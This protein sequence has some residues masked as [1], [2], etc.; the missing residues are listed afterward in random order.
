MA[1]IP[2][3]IAALPQERRFCWVPGE[4][5]RGLSIDGSQ[6]QVHLGAAAAPFFFTWKA[7]EQCHPVGGTEWETSSIYIRLNLNIRLNGIYLHWH[8]GIERE[9][10]R[11]ARRH[12]AGFEGKN[13]PLVSGIRLNQAQPSV[14]SLSFPAASRPSL[15]F[16]PLG[17]SWVAMIART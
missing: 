10:E 3:S 5:T 11:N 1:E 14:R 4:F 16:V 7:A 2:A 15:A 13:C 9:R 17:G 6:L 12:G 8:G